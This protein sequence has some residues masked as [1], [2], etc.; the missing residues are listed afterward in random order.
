ML[1]AECQE[2]VIWSPWPNSTVPVVSYAMFVVSGLLK[3]KLKT[4]GKV[5]EATSQQTTANVKYKCSM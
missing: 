5:P 4:I 2:L 3:Q 1:V